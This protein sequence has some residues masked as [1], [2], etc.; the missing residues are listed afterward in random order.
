MSKSNA[1]ELDLLAYTLQKV[2]PSW[3]AITDL[4][5]ALH[6]SDPGEAGDQTTN[7]A[8]YTGY[9]RATISRST[10]AWTISSTT[11]AANVGVIS[12]PA[13][14]AGSNTATYVSVGSSFSGAGKILYSG[15]LT[16]SLAI[17]A[18]ITP[19]FNTASLTITEE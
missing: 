18:G 6:T 2:A 19:S 15:A 4:F 16:A 11:A 9:T 3:D 10:S 17:S 13:C 7:E 14:T 1:S 8:N 5:L 12:F